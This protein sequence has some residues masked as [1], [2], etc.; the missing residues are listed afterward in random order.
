[1]MLKLHDLQAFASLL[2]HAS[3]LKQF[4]PAEATYRMPHSISLLV[5]RRLNRFALIVTL[6]FCT[7]TVARPQ[8]ISPDEIIHK[9][10]QA[11][12]HRTNSIAGYT[13]QELYSVYR[14][15]DSAPSAQVTVKTVYTRNHGKEYTPLSQ[16]GSGL[17]RSV[18]INHILAHEKEMA[19]AANRESVALTSANYEMTP[20]P[21]TVDYNGHT[22]VIVNL[23][24][25]RKISYLFNGKGWF[26]TH[27][28]TLVHIEGIPAASPSF[29]TGQTGGRRDYTKIDG[30]S[31]AQHA[32]MQS[33]SRLFGDTLLK[34]DYSN[35]QI[36]LD[37][38][39]ASTLSGH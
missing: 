22:C 11:V 8:S 4:H 12:A 21:G 30:F 14:N 9:I 13:V 31:M 16:S 1:M 24:A 3:N 39:S 20:E 17:M 28:F 37:P 25:R 15:R 26:D 35:Y 18:V 19:T 32:E 6:F 33:H 27:D 5:S 36:Q 29:F 34:I 7:L 23:K 38:T 2:I 10:D